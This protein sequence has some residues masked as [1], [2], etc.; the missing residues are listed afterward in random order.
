[1]GLVL[2]LAAAGL[3]A[4]PALTRTWGARVPA[5]EWARLTLAALAAGA[6]MFELAAV[7][8]ALPTILRAA[9]APLLADACERTLGGLTPGGPVAGWAAAAVAVSVPVLAGRGIRRARCAQRTVLAEPWLGEHRSFLGHDLVV[10]PTQQL[11]AVSVDGP[12]PQILVSEGLVASVTRSELDLILRHEAAHLDCHHQ[13]Y[14]LTAAAIEEGLVFLPFVRR[15]TAVLR[16]A[17]E[18]W[19]DDTAAGADPQARGALRSALLHVTGVSVG[20]EL[21]AFSPADTVVERL[22]ALEAPPPAPTPRRQAA[23]YLPGFGVGGLACFALGAA[24]ANAHLVLAVS[25]HCPM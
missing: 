21:A 18:R 19:A 8:Y 15:S 16:A 11:V 3:T 24:V 23:V 1:M 20:P 7:L 6:V 9:H 14:L 25:G 22:A 12:H 2:L 4:V 10:L 13:R 17:L 5:P